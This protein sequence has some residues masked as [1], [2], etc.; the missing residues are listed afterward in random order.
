MTGETNRH[1]TS[2]TVLSSPS[3]CSPTTRH[4]YPYLCAKLKIGAE[5][6]A[7]KRRKTAKTKERNEKRKKRRIKKE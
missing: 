4:S 7:E 2:V 5:A 1:H 6:G 3:Q